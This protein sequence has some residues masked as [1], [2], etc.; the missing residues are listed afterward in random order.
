MKA[1]LQQIIESREES[2]PASSLPKAVNCQGKS[3]CAW[4]RLSSLP[5]F[6][7]NIEQLDPR[8]VRRIVR[9]VRKGGTSM[10]HP[11]PLSE[12]AELYLVGLQQELDHLAQVLELKIVRTDA[13]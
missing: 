6:S 9:A 3:V 2:K 4:Y 1:N 7:R 12:G 5:A 10:S 11:C 13:S 8:F